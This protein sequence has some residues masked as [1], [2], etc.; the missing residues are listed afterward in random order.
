MIPPHA[1]QLRLAEI[2]DAA[3]IA[4]IYSLYIRT[5][6]ITFEEVEVDA[7]EMALRIA[8]VYSKDL[9]WYVAVERDSV[10]GY[11]YATPWRSR[12]AYRFAVEVTV[13]VAAGHARK[14]IGASLYIKLLGALRMNGYRTAIAGIALP[15]D[16][17]VALHE[18]CG[19]QKVAHFQQVGFKLDRWIDVAYW[20][21]T[22]GTSDDYPSSTPLDTKPDF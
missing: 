5:T 6:T 10:V 4:A 3:A 16:E 15:N 13:Y 8:E 18:R 17:S 11:A 2:N 7:A 19:F 20:Q 1:A 14:G 9:P 12:S 22:W 21:L